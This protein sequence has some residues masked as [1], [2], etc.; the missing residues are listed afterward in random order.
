MQQLGFAGATLD[1]PRKLKIAASSA[2]PVLLDFADTRSIF[3]C[4]PSKLA[5]DLSTCA[6]VQRYLLCISLRSLQR[7]SCDDMTLAIQPSGLSKWCTH[8]FASA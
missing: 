2:C 3:N 8:K 4:G 1:I 6:L 5:P 7:M